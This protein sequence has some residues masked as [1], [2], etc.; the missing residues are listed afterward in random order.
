MRAA[1]KRDA[2]LERAKTR[3][4]RQLKTLFN[5][6]TSRVTALIKDPDTYSISEKFDLAVGTKIVNDLRR[7]LEDAGLDDVVGSYVEQFS[8]ITRASLQ[9]F[10]S[11]GAKPDL[12]GV[13]RDALESLI[14]F[15]EITLRDSIDRRFVEPLRDGIFQ[16][17]FGNL[18]RQ[19]IVDNILTKID[20]MSPAQTNV[21][22]NST[23]AQFARTVTVEKAETLNM[24]IFVY[25][26]PN[27]EITSPQCEH[28]LT[29]DDHEMEGALYKDEIS[30]DLHEDLRANPLTNGGHPNC[31]HEYLPITTE[32][33]KSQGFK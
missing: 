23:F 24:E 20:Y 14:R 9:Y 15:N 2:N 13:D 25:V 27:D 6:Y 19:L 26:G 10:E 31:R 4:E 3:L 17:T 16:N 33:A 5:N 11:F 18:P 1:L 30:A 29:I 12:G 8:G 28:L 7:I 21:L 32:F 22:V